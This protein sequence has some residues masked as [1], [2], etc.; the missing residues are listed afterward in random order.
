MLSDDIAIILLW[1]VYGHNLSKF[2]GKAQDG[3]D[4]PTA[5]I[6]AQLVKLV[7]GSSQGNG[8]QLEAGHQELVHDFHALIKSL[9]SEFCKPPK[10]T[11]PAEATN[12][13][14]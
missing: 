3:S 6:L 10:P 7:Q 9:P 8:I 13:S 11:T 12:C 4:I 5:D 1:E 2:L 14:F